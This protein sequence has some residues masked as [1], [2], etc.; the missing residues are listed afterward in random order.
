MVLPLSVCANG[1]RPQLF[2]LDTTSPLLPTQVLTEWLR[3]VHLT[4]AVSAMTAAANC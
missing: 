1:E 3:W 2:P 4:A